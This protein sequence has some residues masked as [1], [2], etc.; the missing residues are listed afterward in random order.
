[1][2]AQQP[3]VHLRVRID[4][5]AQTLTSLASGDESA[6]RD[7]VRRLVKVLGEIDKIGTAIGSECGPKGGSARD[8]IRAYLIMHQGQVIEGDELRVVSG[9]SEYGRRVRELRVQEGFQIETGATQDPGAERALKPDQYVLVSSQPDEDSARRWKLAND[10]R[11]SRKGSKSQLL[12]FFLANVGRVLTSAE[13]EYVANNRS[14][15]G[16]RIRE[17]RT[18]DGFPIATRFTGRPDLQMGQYVLES[19]QRRAEQHDRHIPHDVQKAVY[20]RDNNRCVC[21]RWSVESSHEGPPRILELHHVQAHKERGPN[22]VENLVVLCSIC[23]DEVHS[24]R[25]TVTR[26]DSGFLCVK[27]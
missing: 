3:E 15:F 27:R 23:H 10:I 18:E 19:A 11:R 20:Q 24:G 22:T 26:T 13:L 6:V 7:R 17:L 12:D 21:C 14:E 2:G 1:V 8:R 16:R 5:L 25:I 4:R 9:I